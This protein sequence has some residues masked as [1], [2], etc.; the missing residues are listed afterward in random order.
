MAILKGNQP[1]V[2]FTAV[3]L[4][5]IG[6]IVWGISE[7]MSGIENVER[8]KSL[9]KIGTWTMVAGGVCL[10]AT[11]FVSGGVKKKV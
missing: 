1:K 4:L 5:I 6:A 7:G 2:F 8:S 9:S 10:V 3:A 11:F